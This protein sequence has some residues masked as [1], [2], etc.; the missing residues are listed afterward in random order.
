MQSG[1]AAQ[2]GGSAQA[3][4]IKRLDGSP[5]RVLVVARRAQPGRAAGRPA[6]CAARGWE[7]PGHGDGASAVRTAR[8]FR[9]DAIVLDMMLPDLDGLEVLPP[10]PAGRATCACCS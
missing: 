8:E 6:S 3:A 2:P 7:I 4:P 10:G 9:P 5:I 1:E